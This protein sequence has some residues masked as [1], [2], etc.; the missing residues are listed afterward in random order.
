[1]FIINLGY[2]LSTSIALIKKNSFTLK[3]L[4]PE[5]MIDVDYPDDLALLGNT[6]AQVEFLL[7]SLDHVAERIGFYEN[8]NKTESICLKQER[9]VSTLSGKPLKLF[10]QRIYLAI[11]ISSTESDVNICLAKTWSAIDRLSII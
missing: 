6:P 4:E 10:D 11:H 3:T 7:H 2:L 8:A 5:T 9:V 1:M